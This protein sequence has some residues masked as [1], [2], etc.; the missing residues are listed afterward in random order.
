MLNV[1]R[2]LS[3]LLLLATAPLAACAQDPSDEIDSGNPD[4][5]YLEHLVK[6]KI[7]SIRLDLGL[8]PLVNDSILYIASKDHAGYL[9]RKKTLSHFE[10]K[11]SKKTPQKR[12]EY[13]KAKNYFTG[14]NVASTYALMPVRSKGSKKSHINRTYDDAANDLVK[15]WRKSKKHYKNII[16]SRYQVT[17]VAIA[18]DPKTK[19]IKAVQMFAEVKSKF[20]FTENTNMFIYEDPYTI[21]Y[22]L[23]SLDQVAHVPHAKRHAWGLK[24]PKKKYKRCRECR[25]IVRQRKNFGGYID[26]AQ[27]IHIVVGTP[28]LVRA[29]TI[30]VRDGLAV[31]TVKFDDYRCGNKQYFLRP[32][33]RN[34]QCIGNGAVQK[35]MYNLRIRKDWRKARRA[36]NVAIRIPNAFKY[37]RPRLVHWQPWKAFPILFDRWPGVPVDLVLGKLPANSDSVLYDINLHIIRSKRAC[38][39]IHFTDFCGEPFQ[40]YEPLPMYSEPVSLSLPLPPDTVRYDFTMSFGRS[41]YVLAQEALQPLLDTLRRNDTTL[42]R[43]GIE[44]FASV[45]GDS[46]LNAGLLQ[47]RVDAITSVIGQL[48]GNV[49]VQVTGIGE[50]WDHFMKAIDTTKFTSWKKLSHAE[51]KQRLENPENKGFLEPIFEK[52]RRTMV[53]VWVI[54]PVIIKASTTA[55]MIEEYKAGLSKQVTAASTPVLATLQQKLYMRSLTDSSARKAL[56]STNVPLTPFSN[57]LYTNRLYMMAKYMPPADPRSK[58][59]FYESLKKVALM[60]TSTSI[61]RFNHLSYLVKEWNNDT[62]YDGALEPA[63]MSK[64]LR[65]IGAVEGITPDTLELLAMNFYFKAISYCLVHPSEENEKLRHKGLNT[66]YRY[67]LKHNPADTVALKVARLFLWHGENDRAYSLLKRYALKKDPNHELLILFLKM[68]YVHSEEDPRNRFNKWLFDA[69]GILTDKEWCEMI[70]GICNMSFQV[71]DNEKVRNVYCEKCGDH[72]DLNERYRQQRKELLE[73]KQP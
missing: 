65:K 51:I 70:G 16:T 23:V 53:K 72:Q 44:V 26:S 8:Y 68:S 30:R 52:E 24:M 34:G 20:V 22:D 63:W 50:S 48:K 38:S 49:P 28:G 10:D 25:S 73:K 58:W 46:A 31:E 27:N 54:K 6:T 47:K 62:L 13:Y 37:L 21:E 40:Q 7:D 14:E 45:E 61:E 11:E 66:I 67:C 59:E 56:L 32:S 69:A 55:Q 12:A 41:G 42:V 60:Q 4:L 33:H 3:L 18:Y 19:S 43:I 57:K 29:L 9:V 5:P 1:L 2:L 64:Q 17:G 15:M 71:L 36:F 39:I 35:P